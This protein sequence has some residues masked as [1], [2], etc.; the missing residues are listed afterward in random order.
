MRPR[1]PNT[2]AQADAR[3]TAVLCKGQAARGWL[4]T[5]GAMRYVLARA[6]AL[7]LLWVG[8]PSAVAE[9]VCSPKVVRPGGT[10]TLRMPVPHGG[11]F[12]V[13]NPK[14]EF[15]FISYKKAS[16]DEPI[17]PIDPRAFRTTAEVTLAV[18]T[19]VGIPVRDGFEKPEPIFQRP[20]VYRFLVAENL[21]TESPPGLLKCTVRYQPR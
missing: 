12:G 1:L 21:E 9:L 3:T 15:Q 11:D 13:W 7:L 17:P 2:A 18:A 4:R 6:I 16:A 10:V 14:G 8:S 20:G 19:A 5:L